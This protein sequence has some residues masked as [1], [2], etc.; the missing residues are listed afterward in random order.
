MKCRKSVLILAV[1]VMMCSFVSASDSNKASSKPQATKTDYT[2]LIS[3]Y[4][5]LVNSSSWEYESEDRYYR[6]EFIHS[7]VI[8]GVTYYPITSYATK[9]KENLPSFLLSLR[10]TD[11]LLIDNGKIYRVYEKNWDI[12]KE[13]E[14]SDATKSSKLLIY[15]FTKSRKTPPTVVNSVEYTDCLEVEG[16]A[17]SAE[18]KRVIFASS[19]GKIH[20]YGGLVGKDLIKYST[21]T[22]EQK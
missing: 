16:N 2:K 12:S 17:Y 5:P 10:H 11:Y 13:S 1:L 22:K 19:I 4:F 20:G 18:D 3:Q 21:P 8:S 15:D 6:L 9:F 14:P 7:E